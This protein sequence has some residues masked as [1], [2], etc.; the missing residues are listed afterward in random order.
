M[1]RRITPQNCDCGCGGTTKSGQYLPGHN[2]RRMLC[3][4]QDEHELLLAYLPTTAQMAQDAD[5]DGAEHW[6]GLLAKL[7]KIGQ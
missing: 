4:S 2:T 3:L 5:A 6:D 7:A 1:P